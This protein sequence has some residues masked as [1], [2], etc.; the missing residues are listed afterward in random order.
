MYV[1]ILTLKNYSSKFWN[2]IFKESKYNIYQER[3]FNKKSSGLS[4]D[5]L[6]IKCR[7]NKINRNIDDQNIY[8][9]IGISSLVGLNK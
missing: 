6:L 1:L 3:I 9:H 5:V 7:L 8:Q 4:S 2:Y